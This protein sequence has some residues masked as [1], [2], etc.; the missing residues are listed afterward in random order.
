MTLLHDLHLRL[1]WERIRFCLRSVWAKWSS[2]ARPNGLLVP[3]KFGQMGTV[4]QILGATTSPNGSRNGRLMPKT[5]EPGGGLG[6][7]RPEMTSFA[8]VNT[9]SSMGS[10][11]LP[12][13]VFCWLGW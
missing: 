12:V 8:L 9:A 4:G 2:P 1:I 11:S 3:T 6:G 5:G 13:K 7:Q 10:V